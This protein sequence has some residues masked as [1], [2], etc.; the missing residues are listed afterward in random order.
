MQRTRL[1]TFRQ[2]RVV[3]IVDVVAVVVVI[4]IGAYSLVTGNRARQLRGSTPRDDVGPINPVVAYSGSRSCCSRHEGRQR[5]RCFGRRFTPLGVDDPFD[6]GVDSSP[7]QDSRTS[8]GKDSAGAIEVAGLLLAL[9]LDVTATND[10]AMRAFSTG[11]LSFAI[12]DV[13]SATGPSKE[14]ACSARG[15]YGQRRVLHPSVDAVETGLNG[16]ASF[17][18]T[19]ALEGLVAG[20]TSLAKKSLKRTFLG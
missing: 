8:P 4:F 14:M 13:S 11:F 18:F 6:K 12:P 1:E 5:S 15:V 10:E 2:S 9:F 16:R 3:V 7:D 20:W 17:S 19:R